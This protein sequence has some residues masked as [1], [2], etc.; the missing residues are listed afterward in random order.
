MRKYE[1]AKD[2]EKG[3]KKVNEHSVFTNVACKKRVGSLTSKDDSIDV[4][5]L[6][7]LGEVIVNLPNLVYGQTAKDIASYKA[8]EIVE[9]KDNFDKACRTKAYPA[10]QKTPFHKAVRAANLVVSAIITSNEGR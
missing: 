9:N 6:T 1:T 2:L 4:S 3:S 7:A 10:A 8:N 5:A